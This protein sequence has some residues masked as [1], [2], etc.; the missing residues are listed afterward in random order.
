MTA[1]SSI[2]ASEIPWAEKPG[3]L[4]SIGPQRVGHKLATKQQ[5]FKIKQL[6]HLTKKN[7]LRNKRIFELQ[8]NIS[9][10]QRYCFIT[11]SPLILKTCEK[12]CI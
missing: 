10:P 6:F 2:F 1:H 8:Q 12:H 11:E 4:Q 5:F 7:F 9:L 3:G